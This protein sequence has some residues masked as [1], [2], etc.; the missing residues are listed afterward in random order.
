MT[1]A[2]LFSLVTLAPL[3]L[4]PLAVEPKLEVA[5]RGERVLFDVSGPSQPFVGIVLGS[6]SYQTSHYLVGLPPLL[7]DGVVLGFGVGDA[8]TP[9]HLELA[10]GALP[11]GV[12]LFAQGVTLDDGALA[13]SEVMR[14]AIDR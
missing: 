3:T 11:A 10:A 14:F 4:A 9:M 12:R 1:P 8:T 7:T 2:L 13:S 6:L 5:V